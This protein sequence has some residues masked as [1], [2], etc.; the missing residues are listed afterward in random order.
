MAKTLVYQMYPISWECYGGL[1]AM[2][3]HL[4]R[5]EQLE[6][7]CVWISPLFPSPRYDHGY[8]VADY[9][10]ID[11]RFGTMEDFDG[12]VETAHQLGMKVLMDLVLNHT[13]T[14]HEWF[15][16]HPEFYCWEEIDRPDWHNLFDGESAWQYDEER[17]EYYLHLFHEK[18]AD[19]NWFPDG[20]EGDVNQILA[21]QFQEI[22]DF[23]TLEHGVDGFRLDVPQAINKDLSSSSLELTDLMFGDYAVRVLNAVFDS[24][25]DVFLIM[26]CMDPTFGELI[27]YYT[28]NT[29]INFAMNMLLKDEFNYET[30]SSIELVML[31]FRDLIAQHAENPHFMLD[32]ES[33]DAP[34]F[35]S[36]GCS[37]RDEMRLM[38]NSDAKAICIYQGQELGLMNPGMDELS[39]EMM[40][41]LD[42][43]TSMR[44]A[45]GESLNDL[46]KLS[47]ANARVPLYLRNYDWTHENYALEWV[48][49]WVR[50]WKD[51]R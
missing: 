13:S 28:E 45:K 39:D 44:Y 26:E 22:I 41:G 17:G 35:I 30:F 36:R 15:R 16:N 11:P 46:R 23:W 40:L 42:A 48:K 33:H 9:M 4:H 10:A 21:R 7:D 6:V 37:M 32:L 51:K 49:D 3:E 14:E 12:F 43:Q 20:P 50:Y 29:P 38:F 34:R 8:D 5:I 25:E 1:T 27:E 24:M 47:R 2:T 31:R 18:Q 19:L